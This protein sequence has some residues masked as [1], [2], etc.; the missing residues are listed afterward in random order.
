MF[1]FIDNG[2]RKI[3][4]LFK[5]YNKDNNSTNLLILFK[6][7]LQVKFVYVL[8]LSMPDLLVDTKH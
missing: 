7:L 1:Y 4:N 2:A 8:C 3:E 6:Y 5:I